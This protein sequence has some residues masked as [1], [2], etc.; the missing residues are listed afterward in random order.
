MHEIKRENIHLFVNDAR[1]RIMELWGQL[2]MSDAEKSYFQAMYSEEYSDDLLQT[3]EMEIRRLNTL[4]EKR[5]PILN[6]VAKHRDLMNDKEQLAI[7]ATDVTRLMGR[8]G[9][10]GRD[11]TRLLREEKMRKRLA[12]ELPRVEVELKKA[13]EEWDEQHGSPFLVDGEDYLEILIKTSTVAASRSRTPGPGATPGFRGRA[14][15]V[16]AMS[17]ASAMANARS[18]S[19]PADKQ[20]PPMRSK[21]PTVRSKTP[22]ARPKT[23]AGNSLQHSQSLT[24]TIG[25]STG[26]GLQSAQSSYSTSSYT[27]NYSTSSGASSTVDRAGSVRTPATF[28]GRHLPQLTATTTKTPTRLQRPALSTFQGGQMSPQRHDPP[29]TA[30]LNGTMT[31]GRSNAMTIKPRTPMKAIP[32][33]QSL[34]QPPDQDREQNSTPR[35]H[36]VHAR[37]SQRSIRSVSPAESAN[38][39]TYPGTDDEDDHAQHNTPKQNMYPPASIGFKKTSSSYTE[40]QRNFSVSTVNS[41][42]PTSGSENWE[43]YGDDSEPESEADPRAAYYKAKQSSTPRSGFTGYG[44]PKSIGLVRESMGDQDEWMSEVN[45]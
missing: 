16:G 45:Y 22:T 33:M 39:E 21:T 26:R 31:L 18:R 36:S 7:S 28:G 43:T 17:S 42:M 2:Y 11:P 10:G 8:G 20:Q 40:P 9:P 35:P 3:H 12:K 44:H 23:P 32:K 24:S 37:H 25:R 14:N 5:A 30:P 38:Y 1:N 6:L 29:H 19:R 4:I 15:T 41:D 34:F 13:L 27:S